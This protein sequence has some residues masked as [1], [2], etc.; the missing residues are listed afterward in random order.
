[1]RD[2]GAAHLHQRG[3]LLHTLFPVAEDP[4]D[5]DTGLI[6]ELAEQLADHPEVRMLRNRD[7]LLF[8]FVHVINSC[9]YYSIDEMIRLETK[10][11][12]TERA[13][14]QR[15]QFLPLTGIV[16]LSIKYMFN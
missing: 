10:S 7:D 11:A 8:F 9:V 13:P 14:A 5:P 16:R 15:L 1:M 12:R 3:D 6:A 4:E 2:R